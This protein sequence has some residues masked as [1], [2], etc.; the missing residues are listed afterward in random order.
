MTMIMTFYP[1]GGI[2]CLSKAY[3]EAANKAAEANIECLLGYG[4]K[5]IPGLLFATNGTSRE[6]THDAVSCVGI[7]APMPMGGKLF[8]SKACNAWARCRSVRIE[9]P[10]GS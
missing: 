10:V 2:P 7:S 4:G 1:T 3:R 9:T 8:V 6:F 5:L